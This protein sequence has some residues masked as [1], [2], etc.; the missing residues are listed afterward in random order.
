METAKAPCLI[1]AMSHGEL[2]QAWPSNFIF[3]VPVAFFSLGTISIPVVGK[4]PDVILELVSCTI[5][6]SRHPRGFHCY[7]QAIVVTGIALEGDR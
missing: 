3:V 1:E 5:L 2:F 4:K 6:Y 7:E